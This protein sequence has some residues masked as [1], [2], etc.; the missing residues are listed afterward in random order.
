MDDSRGVLA[1]DL[2]FHQAQQ[3]K[4]VADGTV[5]VWPAGSTVM[6][7]LQNIVILS[8]S[9]EIADVTDSSS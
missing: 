3:L 8:K 7:N 6:F 2:F 5:W 4:D 1:R 9:G